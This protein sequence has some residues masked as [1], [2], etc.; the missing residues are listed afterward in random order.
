MFSSLA[1]TYKSGIIDMINSAFG[2][3]LFDDVFSFLSFSG[4]SYSND[5]WNI[6]LRVYNNVMLPFGCALMVL[7]FLIFLMNKASEQSFSIEVMAKTFIKL[8]FA[9]MFMRSGI[10]ILGN[11]IGAGGSLIHSV[12]GSITSTNTMA[13]QLITMLN[14]DVAGQTGLGSLMTAI[15]W[16]IKLLIPFL[17]A[18]IM[19]AIVSIIAIGRIIELAIKA[20]FAPIAFADMFAEGTNGQGFRFIKGF[21]ATC[22]QGAVIA[23]IAIIYAQIAPSIFTAASTDF[24]GGILSYLVSGFAA[25]ALVVKSQAIAKEIVGS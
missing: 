16:Y 13:D 22:L 23:V 10:N 11:L 14:N 19:K 9:Y 21:L 8:V 4:Q 6:V 5:I 7:W 2:G 15:F 20:C 1:E 17:F 25:V 18:L 12:R 3:G 24:W